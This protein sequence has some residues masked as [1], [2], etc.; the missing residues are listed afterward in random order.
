MSSSPLLSAARDARRQLE[1]E[2]STLEAK[3][4]KSSGELARLDALQRQIGAASS[5]IARLEQQQQP[6]TDKSSSARMIEFSVSTV[7]GASIQMRAKGSA[8]CGKVVRTFCQQTGAVTSDAAVLRNAAGEKFAPDASH[9][10][11]RRRRTARA[12]GHR[13]R[14]RRRSILYRI[15]DA[16]ENFLEMRSKNS[17]RIGKVSRWLARQL[18]CWLAGRR[19]PATRPAR[20]G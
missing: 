17:V 5:D 2:R 1:A 7:R 13:G 6:Q 11:V 3:T 16:S 14:S 19:R 12:L 4:T 10:G 15:V 18:S 8:L 9:S 20:C